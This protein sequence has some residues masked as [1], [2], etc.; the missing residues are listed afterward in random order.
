MRVS[1]PD[2]LQARLK[3]LEAR[4]RLNRDRREWQW[5]RFLTKPER[6]RLRKILERTAS[7]APADRASEL[8]EAEVWWLDEA[9]AREAK[10]PCDVS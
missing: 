9:M 7:L 2:R 5:L 8:T 10:S 1:D 3:S 6:D 4:A